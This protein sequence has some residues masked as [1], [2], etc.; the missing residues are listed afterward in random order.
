MEVAE[1]STLSGVGNYKQ[2]FAYATTLLLL[3]SPT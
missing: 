3:W 2:R 1:D